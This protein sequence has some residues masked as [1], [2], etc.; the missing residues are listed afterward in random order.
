[1]ETTNS[2]SDLR[3][4]IDCT[5]ALTIKR[6]DDRRLFERILDLLL[7]IEQPFFYK[8]TYKFLIAECPTLRAGTVIKTEN[9][10]QWFITHRSEFSIIV[11]SVSELDAADVKEMEN[12]SGM[13]EVTSPRI[14]YDQI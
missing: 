10:L 9:G 6:V 13:A 12:Y 1:M 4:I 3:I 8:G 5:H 7:S 11:D 2:H 14:E